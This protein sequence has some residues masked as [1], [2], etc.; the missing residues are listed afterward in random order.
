MDHV[1]R[2]A[3]TPTAANAASDRPM[4]CP[5]ASCSTRLTSTTTSGCVRN[6]LSTSA[7]ATSTSRCRWV[8]ATKRKA[9]PANVPGVITFGAPQSPPRTSGRRVSV[10]PIR[11]EIMA[12]GPS[13]AGSPG[14]DNTYI[15]LNQN[16][17]PPYF[18][19]TVDVNPS[20]SP[21]QFPG[22]RRL[23]GRLTPGVPTRRLRATWRRLHLDQTRPYAL[24]GSLGVQRVFGQDY[25]LEA[26]YVYTKGVHLWNQTRMNIISR[27]T[28][29]QLHPHVHFD[30]V[31]RH[32]GRSD[33]DARGNGGPPVA[34]PRP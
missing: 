29:S 27:V 28:P 4:A 31:G 14:V 20:H 7:C 24:T 2:A 23:N 34:T 18:Q 3:E 5:L 26:R 21:H 8:P 19:T 10:S 12:S 15:N 17:S 1:P 25:T 32:L 9:P 22:Q 13:G 11:P 6:S 33:H 30:A 16:A